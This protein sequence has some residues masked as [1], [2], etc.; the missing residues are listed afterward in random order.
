VVLAVSFLFAGGFS[1]T[2]GKWLINDWGVSEKWMPFG[3]ASL[4]LLPLVFF[5]YLLECYPPPGEEDI[6]SR[7]IRKPMLANDRRGFKRRFGA[8]LSA[9]V[10]LYLL[11]TILRDLR[12]NYMV[13]MWNELGYGQQAGV[14]TKTETI[15]SLVILLLIGCL[16]FI[17]NNIRAMHLIH[18]F[19]V[20][21]FLLAG[22]S[23]VSF[24][25]EAIS[26]AGWMQLN[27]MGLYISYILFNSVY[28][29][30]MLAV[31][32]IAGNVGFLIYTADAWGYL[33]SVGV[34]LTKQFLPGNISWVHYYLQFS[35]CFSLAGLVAS[36]FAWVYFTRKKK[37]GLS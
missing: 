26:G 11:L 24:M 13:G 34:M 23:S 12:D 16:V 19:L 36:I 25:V 30:R 8:G 14:Y 22:L 6:L 20:A 21:G 5:Y 3:V 35:I 15:S 7:T 37:E 10:I 2:V 29:E 33:G 18:A 27:G 32:R 1:R 17:R 28:F 4:F 31:F 9:V